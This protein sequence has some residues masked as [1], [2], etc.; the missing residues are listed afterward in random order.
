MV[1]KTAE[2]VKFDK[3]E[4]IKP[5]IISLRKIFEPMVKSMQSIAKIPEEIKRISEKISKD[6]ESGVPERTANAVEKIADNP[7]LV[8]PPKPDENDLVDPMIKLNAQLQ[9]LLDKGIPAKI[10]EDNKLVKLTEKEIKETQREFIQQEKN[11]KTIREQ[12]ETVKKSD[13][14]AEEMAIALESLSSNM[15]K[16]TDKKQE[17]ETTLGD[18][19]PQ[20]SQSDESGF[21]TPA[22][23]KESYAMGK[24]S[25][26]AGP[27]AI[28]QLKDS[29]MDNIGNPLKSLIKANK[30]H[31]ETMYEHHEVMEDYGE[32][33]EK[34]DKLSILKILAIAAGIGT[35]VYTVKKIAESIIEDSND[36]AKAEKEA[37][38][39]AIKEG[40]GEIEAQYEGETAGTNM[41]LD[42]NQTSPVGNYANRFGTSYEFGIVNDMLGDR[43]HGQNR[44]KYLQ[45]T[46]EQQNKAISDLGFLNQYDFR[47]K[48]P[49]P[50]TVN[51]FDQ[52]NI[53]NSQRGV[54]GSS[55]ASA[56]KDYLLGSGDYVA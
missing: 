5:L 56:D 40:K 17:L 29:F 32:T 23:A 20:P 24:E 13:M 34:A 1:E 18:R 48:Q 49:P 28:M 52:T 50:V 44:E 15:Q 43:M 37:Y 54:G 22:F 12:I 30:E 38:D 21:V 35:I 7:E 6:V 3:E 8:G 2:K 25:L 19:I 11:E 33:G 53:D 46:A 55:K 10:D 42:K 41:L 27:N 39:K 36:I 31:H 16:T 47:D 45:K 4:D 9:L 26:M 14:T 51:K